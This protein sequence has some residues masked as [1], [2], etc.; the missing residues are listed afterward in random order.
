MEKRQIST[1]FLT[2]NIIPNDG[3]EYDETALA[4][5][6]RN[7]LAAALS[8]EFPGDMITVD[9]QRASGSIPEPLRTNID[10]ET[11]SDEAQRVDDIADD[12]Y[13]QTNWDQFT[14]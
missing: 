9:Y 13:E 2:G 14:A 10:G 11:D 7:R 4:N 8:A 6:Y 3:N 5:D 12:V 1:G